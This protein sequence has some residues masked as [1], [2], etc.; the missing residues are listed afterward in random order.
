[1][2]LAGLLAVLYFA[3]P[4]SN[5]FGIQ[6]TGMF[7]STL[8]TYLAFSVV[9]GFT[10]RLHWPRHDIQALLQILTDIG[11]IA[12][13]MHATGGVTSP[14][15]VFLV[16]AVVTGTW[17]LPGRLAYLFASVAALAVLFE[18]GLTTLAMDKAG[19]DEITRA[20]LMGAVIFIA[21]GLTHL[22]IIRARESEAL[23]EQRGIEQNEYAVF[24]IAD[25]FTPVVPVED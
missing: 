23:A 21:A 25:D 11:A 24:T 17:V 16:I 5:P 18:S 20:G 2:V 19:A 14:L 12:L 3:L 10:T 1:V 4:D 6:Q 13:L 22:L 7:R 9:A 15:S 8:M